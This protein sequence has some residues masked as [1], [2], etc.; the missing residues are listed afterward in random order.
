MALPSMVLN[1]DLVGGAH[2][3]GDFGGGPF[4][5]T[6]I[7]RGF[8][9]APPNADYKLTVDTE[10]HTRALAFSFDYWQMV[11]DWAADR[12]FSLMGSRL[13]NGKC[14]RSPL[15]HSISSQLWRLGDEDGAPSRMLAQAAGCEILAELCRLNGA[16]FSPSNGGLA[17]WAERRCIEIMRMRLAEDLSLV[18]LAM[19]VKLSP[20]HFSRKFKQSVG[21]PHGFF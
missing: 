14:F 16:P 4:A 8:Y 18:E 20:F 5:G 19:E 9:L 6:S 12:N 11:V 21:V 3:C 13:Y 15:I 7:K 10:H 1:Q 2:L 17:P